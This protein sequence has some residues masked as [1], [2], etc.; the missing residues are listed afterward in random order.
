MLLL[1]ERKIVWMPFVHIRSCSLILNQLHAFWYY[2]FSFVQ[3][4][5]CNFAV[6][7]LITDC[8]DS[9]LFQLICPLNFHPSKTGL[10][11]WGLQLTLF[12]PWKL[13]SIK[14]I[15]IRL[16][17]RSKQNIS[18]FRLA[19]SKIA[20]KFGMLAF[21]DL[22]GRLRIDRVCYTHNCMPIKPI[23]SLSDRKLS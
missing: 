7:L 5:L 22:I 17:K 1:N 18:W 3:F 9:D 8:R 23:K 12:L 21:T 4:C 14:K 2:W 11:E 13:F 16:R 10:I 15:I 20:V 19:K 6:L